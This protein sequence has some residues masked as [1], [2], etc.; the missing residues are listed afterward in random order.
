M[1]RLS[2]G[3][4]LE[5]IAWIGG[6]PILRGDPRQLVYR[7]APL[8]SAGPDDLSFLSSGRY[9]AQARATRAG[10]VIIRAADAPALPPACALL[11]CEDPYR[12]FAAVG[13]ELAARLAPVAVAGRD[14]SAVVASDAWIGEGV[15]IGPNAVIGAGAVVGEGAVLGAGVVLGSRARVGA[16]S[17]L[18]PRVTLYDGCMLGARCIVHAGAVIGADGFGFAPAGGDWEKIPQLGRVIVGDDVEIGANTTIDRGSL[19]DTV[20]GDGCKLDNQIQIGH[21]VHIGEGSALAGCVGVAGSATIG[22]RCRIGGGAGIL[23]HLEICDDVTVSA[24]SLVTR[25]IRQPGFYS[26]VFPLM[27]NSDWERS[28]ALLRR[29]PDLRARL[30]R[31]ERS[32]DRETR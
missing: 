31:L 32:D 1:E 6:A 7:L 16:G 22:R 24:M 25:S 3:L 15:S 4:D 28:A 27:D 26:G 10:A 19:D 21:N 20:I 14:P 23:G 2:A 11:A 29:L 13:R 12:A 9:L 8:A 17:L 18:Y 5:A 30:R